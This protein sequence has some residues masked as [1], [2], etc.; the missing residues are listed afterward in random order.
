MLEISDK[1]FKAAN[2]KCF[3]NYKYVWN[4]SIASFTEGVD[5]LKEIKYIKKW[6]F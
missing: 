3:N 2:K 6:K 5:S 4:Q 1:N